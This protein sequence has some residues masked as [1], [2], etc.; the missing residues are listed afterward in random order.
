MTGD[1]RNTKMGLEKNC[2]CCSL[3]LHLTKHQ[4]V[5]EFF[6]TSISRVI[7]RFLFAWSHAT[8]LRP[9]MAARVQNVV[10]RSEQSCSPTRNAPLDTVSAFRRRRGNNF[11]FSRPVSDL[12]LVWTFANVS[13]RVHA[14]NFVPKY[15]I[16]CS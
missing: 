9:C 10:F 14:S 16:I 7:L 4:K 6:A 2:Q 12:P 1:C 3:E 11:P 15:Y 5:R 13:L 8:M